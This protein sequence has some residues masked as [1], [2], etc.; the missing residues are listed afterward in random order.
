MEY[1]QGILRWGSVFFSIKLLTN[2]NSLFAAYACASIFT[3]Y[4]VLTGIYGRYTNTLHEL[5]PAIAYNTISF[6]SYDILYILAFDPK[7][8]TFIL[9]HIGASWIAYSV[10]QKKIDLDVVTNY[11]F[12]IELSNV[13]I[14]FYSYTSQRPKFRTLSNLLGLLTSITYIPLRT[15]GLMM[16][17]W[18]MLLDNYAKTN[19]VTLHVLYVSL[20][21]LSFLYSIKLARRTW[22]RIIAYDQTQDRHSPSSCQLLVRNTYDLLVRCDERFW[23]VIT[24]LVKAYVTWYYFFHRFPFLPKVYHIYTTLIVMADYIQITISW[25]FNIHGLSVRYEYYDFVFI[26]VKMMVNGVFGIYPYIQ[27][28][29][30]KS[31]STLTLMQCVHPILVLAIAKSGMYPTASM[32]TSGILLSTNFLLSIIPFAWMYNDTLALW[33]AAAYSFGGAIWYMQFPENYITTRTTK[34][35]NSVG[36][37]HVMTIIGDCL[38]FESVIKH[39]QH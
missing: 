38:F 23:P 24:F 8:Y 22:R 11:F 14:N 15:I 29:P 6:Y 35:L 31:C 18:Y 21:P 19:D 25:L 37:M 1:G 26:N 28:N 12:Y 27:Q 39:A 13:F 7:S 17:T 2:N 16:T 10:L 20:V 4:V 3:Y 5:I 9:H 36:W 32:R 33:T 34:W 30:S